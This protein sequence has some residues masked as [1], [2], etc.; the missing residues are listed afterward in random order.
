[1]VVSAPR[2]TFTWEER[3]GAAAYEIWLGASPEKGLPRFFVGESVMTGISFTPSAD[4]LPGTYYWWVRAKNW[5]G[6]GPW[7]TEGRSVEIFLKRPSPVFR[8]RPE[9]GAVLT[10]PRP[11]LTWEAVPEARA[12]E[13]WIGAGSG[14][15]LPRFFVGESVVTGTSFTPS[16]GLPSGTYYWWV[17]AK[18]SAGDGPWQADEGRQV[19]LQLGAS[20]MAWVLPE[21][22]LSQNYPNPFNG[23]TTIEYHV[24]EADR[25]GQR[26]ADLTLVEIT[27]YNMAGQLVRRLIRE[28]KVPGFYRVTWDGR[29]NEGGEVSSG[30]Y[31]YRM[32]GS[33]FSDTKRMVLLK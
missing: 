15:G 29:D 20:K 24:Q 2:P 31:L 12:Y 3:Y 11:S 7:Q 5:A 22:H 27:I 28:Y 18:N 21:Y 30:I 1:M 4:L 33:V 14:E 32:Q 9:E 25:V 13:I 26:K 10:T 6:D 8:L 16:A 19:T 23:E 17:R